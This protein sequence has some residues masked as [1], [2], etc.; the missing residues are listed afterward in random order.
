MKL[1]VFIYNPVMLAFIF[2]LSFIS[3]D[4]MSKKYHINEYPE[5]FSPDKLLT[6]QEA[7][8]DY[9]FIINSLAD[10]H[11]NIFFLRSK[12]ELEE[13]TRDIISPFITQVK[14]SQD[15]QL[16]FAKLEAFLGDDHSKIQPFGINQ[17]APPF[18]LK[19]FE[20]GFYITSSS[21][22]QLR[23]G[24]QIYAINEQPIDKVWQSLCSVVNSPYGRC[25]DGVREDFFIEAYSLLYQ[26]KTI[27]ITYNNSQGVIEDLIIS[28]KDN[29]HN[30]GS[31]IS[32]SSTLTELDE[33]YVI[34]K[35][36]YCYLKLETVSYS[37]FKK[38]LETFTHNGCTNFVLDLRDNQGGSP[39]DVAGIVNYLS[40]INT[41]EY[42]AAQNQSLE[43]ISNSFT[44]HMIRTI[45]FIL[46]LGFYT[47]ADLRRVLNFPA[48][49]PAKLMPNINRLHNYLAKEEYNQ[50]KQFSVSNLYVI[51]NHNSRSGA[52]I[53]AG[54]LKKFIN[55]TIVG[56]ESFGAAVKQFGG[57][58][59]LE[60]PNS[61]ILYYYS[62]TY[63]DRSGDT[64]GVD[65]VHW[66][67]PFQTGVVPDF[68]SP[69]TIHDFLNSVDAEMNL[70]K[71]LIG[72]NSTVFSD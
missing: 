49:T 44:Q 20:S 63:S 42:F 22:K 9:Y 39:Y 18:T 72:A 19:K 41:V 50:P 43:K 59:S 12:I 8:D 58:L 40:G 13:F 5:N 55:A 23:V 24:T 70:V 28:N 17:F 71:K 34:E 29:V 11:P 30:V 65:S 16:V 48:N 57:R 52:A 7:W 37:Y 51:I 10:A 64:Q 60:A 53:L 46:R 26:Q 45:P 33:H 15:M 54:G 35:S 61:G 69:V 25:L 67:A 62:H 3:F 38:S 14:N 27:L 21:I 68:V 32:S 2:S 66:P 31:A 56:N 4:C 47:R 1:S 36:N 6:T